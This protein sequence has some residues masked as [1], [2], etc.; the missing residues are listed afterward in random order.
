[1]TGMTGVVK[2]WNGLKGFGFI[3]GNN[4]QTDVLFSKREL[5]EDFREVQGKFL[6]GRQVGFQAAQAPDGRYKASA[7]SVNFVEGMPIAGKIKSF[8]DKNGW[9]F[10]TSSALTDDVRFDRSCLATPP[11]VNLVGEL[12]IME[13]GVKP[14]GKLN[15]ATVRFQNAQISE[16]VNG[17]GGQVPPMAYARSG[18]PGRAP[19]RPPPRQAQPA[20]AGLNSVVGTVKS[21]NPRAGYGFLS[22]SGHTGDVKFSGSELQGNHVA[23]GSMVSFTPLQNFDGR[24][25]ALNVTPIAMA[26]EAAMAPVVGYPEPPAKK[27]RMELAT[28]QYGSG[29]IRTYNGAK[30]F[31]F[32]AGEGLTE[33]VFFMRTSLPDGYRELQGNDLQ[34]RSVSFE[35]VK[36][37]DGK[38]RAQNVSF[39]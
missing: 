21:F 2:S 31:G 6:T 7:V 36:T 16:R 15:A 24:L 28:G 17:A 34:G 19:A 14:D 37:S 11:G 8:S 35:I 32:I 26:N 5:P 33:D 22:V 39:V 29:A 27:Q 38:L 3:E 25:Q 23:S 20:Q 18:P 1:M 12:V 13:V 30:G 4:I 10:I 9:G